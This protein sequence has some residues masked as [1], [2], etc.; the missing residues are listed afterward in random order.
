M[1][2]NYIK[3]FNFFNSKLN[4]TNEPKKNTKAIQ[5]KKDDEESENYFFNKRHENKIFYIPDLEEIADDLIKNSKQSIED[6]LLNTQKINKYLNMS[7]IIPLDKKDF[8]QKKKNKQNED[9]SE[10]ENN[11]MN[12][13]VKHEESQNKETTIKSY[14]N[15]NYGENNIFQNFCAEYDNIQKHTEEDKKAYIIRNNENQNENVNSITNANNNN[16]INNTINDNRNEEVTQEIFDQLNE[17]TYTE[18][19]KNVYE[20]PICFKISNKNKDLKYS[21]SK[22]HHVLCNLC[23]A[24]WLTEKLECPLC[25]AK[26]RPK[27]LKRIIFINDNI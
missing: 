18:E 12:K 24:A 15:Y 7:N 25:K 6:I 3:N 17:N 2:K 8:L 13:K 14:S 1:N 5:Y 16:S 20:C 26:A 19:S 10:D 22:C 21:M 9:I 27:T 11:K 23:W 4:N